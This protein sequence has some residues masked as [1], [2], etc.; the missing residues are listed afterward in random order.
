MQITQK[1]WLGASAAIVLA[2]IA[3]AAI[4]LWSQNKGDSGISAYAPL[5]PSC[6]IQQGP[7]QSVFPDG[8]RISLSIGPRP[9]QALKP[10]EIRVTTQG[11]NAQEVE[12]DFRGLGMDMGY[13]RPRLQGDAERQYSG[14]GMLAICVMER[15]PW[16]ATVLV[17]TDDGVMAAPFRFETIRP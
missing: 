5:D 16:E 12:V 15:M 6:D 1:L 8:S 9:I 11:L 14:S 10:L 7:C 3:A 2:A 13:N 4:Q 17:T